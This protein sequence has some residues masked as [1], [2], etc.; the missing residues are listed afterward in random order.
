[1]HKKEVIRTSKAPVPKG[2]YSQAIIY[3]GLV[4]VSGQI[5]LD[6][7]T[8]EMV[9]GGIEE[10][11]KI[12]FENIRAILK[13]ANS[14]FSNILKVTCYLVDI[15]DFKKFN[16]VYKDYFMNDPPARTTVQVSG[17][18]LNAKVEV[19]VIAFINSS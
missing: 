3:N 14:G 13:E 16:T 19:D 15:G 1:M 4:Y 6:P 5:A 12:I 18:P 7:V 17:L 10:E 8:D 2:P 9:L 11:S